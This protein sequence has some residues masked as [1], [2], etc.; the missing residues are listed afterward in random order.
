MIHQATQ[1]CLH[2]VG[3]LRGGKTKAERRVHDEEGKDN[4]NDA[5]D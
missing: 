2:G 3:G 1:P 5:E 4:G